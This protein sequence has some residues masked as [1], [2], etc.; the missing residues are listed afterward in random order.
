M[1]DDE[2]SDVATDDKRSDVDKLSSSIDG[3]ATSLFVLAAVLA[4]IGSNMICA[5]AQL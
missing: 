1:A 3:V 4:I 5:V 2:N